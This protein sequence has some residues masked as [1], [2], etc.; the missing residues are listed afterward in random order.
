MHTFEGLTFGKCACISVIVTSTITLKGRYAR[1]SKGL[2][3]S[4]SMI[5]NSDRLSKQSEFS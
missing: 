3:T 5:S 1:L 2:F 4:W